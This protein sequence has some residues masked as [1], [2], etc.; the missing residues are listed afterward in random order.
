MENKNSRGLRTMA[1]VALLVAVAGISIAFAA[2]T[3]TLNIGGTG[4][5]QTTDWDIHWSATDGGKVVSGSNPL[6]AKGSVSGV[7]ST[8]LTL[9]GIKLIAPGD[10]IEWVLTA[11]ND[12]SIDAELENITNLLDVEVNFND[13]EESDLTAS[14]IKVT[15]TKNPS[16]AI[17][18]K[19]TLN[20]GASQAYLLTIEFNSLAT[21]LP[22]HDVDITITAQ[23]PWV[24]K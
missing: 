6:A 8:T 14:D 9:S 21:E 7:G 4:K 3:Q 16:G 20:A 2:F 10:K 1:I 19:D 15:L 18:T 24:Q 17:A 23:F 12:G 13:L 11:L 22:S 5:I